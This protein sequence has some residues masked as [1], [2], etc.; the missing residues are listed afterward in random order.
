MLIVDV[1]TMVS[2]AEYWFGKNTGDSASLRRVG[3][4]M[5]AVVFL[6]DIP[7]LVIVIIFLRERADD[8]I[9]VISVA[10]SFI[11]MVCNTW[12]GF[13]SLCCSNTVRQRAGADRA[14]RYEANC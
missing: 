13:K 14:E 5:L 4:G 3:Y 12:I 11:S 1:I 8:K 2:R 10:V 9:A 6:E 7:Q